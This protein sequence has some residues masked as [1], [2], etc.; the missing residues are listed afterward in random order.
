MNLTKTA[1]STTRGTRIGRPWRPLWRWPVVLV[2]L[3]MACG[4]ALVGCGGDDNDGNPNPNPNPF[5]VAVKE[6]TGHIADATTARGIGGA[7]V[8]IGT[9]PAQTTSASGN[10]IVPAV[11]IETLVV[12]VNA[13]NYQTAT[14]TLPA[15]QRQFT[16]RLI[17]VGAGDPL[18]PPGTPTD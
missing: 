1:D 6:V 5:P 4:V 2:L 3:G 10:F 18:L 8:V 17:P 9:Q 14:F 15:G 7:T 16:R 11:P 13:P 12:T